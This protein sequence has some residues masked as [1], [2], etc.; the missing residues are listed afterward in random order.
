[1]LR[2]V[3]SPYLIVTSGRTGSSILADAL[4]STGRHGT[5]HEHLTVPGIEL[6]SD[7]L[8]VASPLE[9]GSMIAY[10]D[11]LRARTSTPGGGFGTKLHTPAIPLVT[12]CLASEPDAPGDDA[13]T[14]LSWA[15]PD[16]VVLLSR[17]RDR[18]AA[19]VSRWRAQTTGDWIRP[20]GQGL[21]EPDL[22]VPL[23]EISEIHRLLH[24]ADLRAAAILATAQLPV[25]EVFYDDLVADWDATLVAARLFLGEEGPIPPTAPPTLARQSG[26]RT[27]ADIERWVAAT[28]GCAACGHRAADATSAR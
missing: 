14:L 5:P 17:R 9:G 6:W 21:D 7:R 23:E 20:A 2:R 22:E 26:D 10:L 25:H 24:L 4:A 13:A 11:E 12:R 15:F 19:A 16:A 1:M 27:R 8:G 3:I 18:V 28:G